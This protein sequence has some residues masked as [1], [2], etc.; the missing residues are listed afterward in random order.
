[1]AIVE[2]TEEYRAVLGDVIQDS[3]GFH[4]EPTGTNGN[5][6]LLLPNLV[7]IFLELMNGPLA[8]DI[9]NMV[10]ASFPSVPVI[11]VASGAA[12]DQIIG[13]LKQG[14]ADFIS[15]PLQASEV[16]PRIYKLLASIK[17]RRGGSKKFCA[18]TVDSLN[19]IG[20][21]P[22]FA[23]ELNKLAAIADCDASVVIS[24]ETGTGKEVIARAIHQLSSRSE[25][26]F[27]PL[28]C[29][30]IPPE[31]LE[32]EMFGH[33]K[34]AYTG[35][36]SRQIGLVQGADGGVLFLDEVDSLPLSSQVKLLRFLQEKEFRPL[37]AV[38][39]QKADV[40]ILA[41][42]NANLEAAVGK[43]LFRWDF[44]Y[45][46]KVLSIHLPPLR[47]RVEDIPLLAEHFA[48][49]YASVYGKSIDSLSKGFIDELTLHH[50]PGNVRELQHVIERA[51]ILC[52]ES[53]ITIRHL[54]IQNNGMEKTPKSFQEMKA[55]MIKMF[56][57]N[58]LQ[59]LLKEYNGNISKAANSVGKNR[60]A[61]WELLR[62]HNID[63]MDY[64]S[65]AS[66]AG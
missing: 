34:G 54:D 29:G 15:I 19:L 21:A 51:V 16:M 6:H 63:A 17:G 13:L 60:R 1:M 43:G 36:G 45:R 66:T 22:K 8:E 61:F 28:N 49:K 2:S 5:N 7:F 10:M 65:G 57:Q 31:L 24:G 46:L 56:E 50:W 64:R 23:H 53:V 59:K 4:L 3:M 35:A 41:A 25:N 37:G 55:D 18:N 33:E 14:A 30:A 44:Y 62:K 42:S 9:L 32:N 27:I 12:P 26:P 38:R 58:Y 47:E 20:R 11:V 52:N 39:T 40:R 48:Q